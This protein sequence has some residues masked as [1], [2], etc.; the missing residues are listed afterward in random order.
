MTNTVAGRHIGIT[1]CHT[2]VFCPRLVEQLNHGGTQL[3]SLKLGPW[4]HAMQR[5]FS[6]A[7][8]IQ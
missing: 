2:D 6:T 3:G 1:N 8:W 5:A 4:M 7:C